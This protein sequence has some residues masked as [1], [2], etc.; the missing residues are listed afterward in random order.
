MINGTASE[1]ELL[2]SEAVLAFDIGPP[3]DLELERQYLS[4]LILSYGVNLHGVDG[5]CFHDYWHG[6]LFL[7]V[8]RNRGPLVVRRILLEPKP[9]WVGKRFAGHFARLFVRADGTDCSGLVR[10]LPQYARELKEI[11]RKRKMWHQGIDM[12][13]RSQEPWER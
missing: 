4:A 11:R 6:W 8:R 7:S 12:L 1:R 3:R 2:E 13:I 9:R 5:W 10:H